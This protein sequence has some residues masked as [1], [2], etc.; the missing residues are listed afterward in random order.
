MKNE[1]AISCA[2]CGAALE[3]C[4]FRKGSESFVKRL[5]IRFA[6]VICHLWLAV[7]HFCL[8]EE[9][10]TFFRDEREGRNRRMK[11]EAINTKFP[12]TYV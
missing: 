6:F 4:K 2:R 5:V 11:R 7:T 12:D 10:R 3:D 1:K 9:G 8:I